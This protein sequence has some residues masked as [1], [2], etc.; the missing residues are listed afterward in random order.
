MTKMYATV[1]AT[2]P[3]ETDK[4]DE[5][6]ASSLKVVEL[7]QKQNI[8]AASPNP[9]DL[10]LD[11][12]GSSATNEDFL[13]AVFGSDSSEYRPVLVSFPENPYHVENKLWT[14]QAWKIDKEHPFLSVEC[15]N[16]FSLATFRPDKE[17]N[18]RRLKSRF[19]ALHAVMLDDI[20]TKIPLDRLQLQ[21]SWLLETSP[22]NF[23]AGYLFRQ[24]LSDGKQADRLM[25]AIIE[26]HLCDPGAGGPRTRLARLPQGNNGKHSPAFSC[27]LR[28]W[29]PELRY[30]MEEIT[31]GLQLDVTETGRQKKT[32]HH[33]VI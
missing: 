12:K 16:F 7:Q 2:S 28:Q 33:T 22:Q 24:A 29:H 6:N 11:A 8:P 25:K 26:A 19:V 18:Y 3:W 15:N 32:E 10:T 31:L 14:G 20:G 30:S 1:S 21:P 13:H 4:T 5:T 9:K 17:G 23:Q 27:K